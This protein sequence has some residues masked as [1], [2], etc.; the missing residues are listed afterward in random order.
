MKTILVELIILS[1]SGNAMAGGGSS[2]GNGGDTVQHFLEGTRYSLA[3]T[4]ERIYGEKNNREICNAVEGLT[5]E[6][7]AECSKFILETGQQIIILNRR[8]PPTEL[9]LVAE[10]LFVQNPNGSQRQVEA[11]TNLGAEGNIKFHYASVKNFSPEKMFRL[12]AHEFGHK[13]SFENRFVDDNSATREFSSGRQLID[14]VAAALAKYAIN[15]GI[16]SGQFVL[17]DEFECKIS[18]AGAPPEIHG[19]LAPRRFIA[20]DFD[21]YD[22]RI[23][24]HGNGR[25]ATPESSSFIYLDL[26]LVVHERF[27]CKSKPE[28]GQ[29]FV[30]LSVVRTHT[31]NGNSEPPPPE[32][33]AEELY[34]DYNPI[35][36]EKPKPMAIKYGQHLFECN[37]SGGMASSR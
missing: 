12:V 34:E 35:C 37:Y 27:G 13:V 36:E 15:L 23:G 32:L 8:Q 3:Q 9:L 21:Q 22:V 2:I 14:S 10:P 17:Q 6:Q 30:K 33:L 5:T 7:K 4:L 20:G 26:K 16:I 29:R 24:E 11:I 25:I 31:K 18:K 28:K 1:L 19:A